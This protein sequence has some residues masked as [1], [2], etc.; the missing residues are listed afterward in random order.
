MPVILGRLGAFGCASTPVEITSTIQKARVLI[1]SPAV[2]WFADAFYRT[3]WRRL[4][5]K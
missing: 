2:R 3:V 5:L 4:A 1:M